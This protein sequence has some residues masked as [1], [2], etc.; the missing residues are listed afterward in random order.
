MTC[1]RLPCH[2]LPAVPVPS[3]AAST[4]L[5]LSIENVKRCV[6]LG[7]APRAD[8]LA[9]ALWRDRRET[10]EERGRQRDTSG[11][12]KAAPSARAK[13]AIGSGLGAVA[14]T[15]PVRRGDALTCAISRTRSS[16][17]I[18][19]IHWVPPSPNSK[20]ST[21]AQHAS[22]ATEDETGAE[23]HDATPSWARLQRP[24][25]RP[26]ATS[27]ARSRFAPRPLRSARRPAANRTS[28]PP[29]R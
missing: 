27:G 3:I 29:S 19:D 20:A 26:V 15:G 1:L 23:A 17:A 14:L 10:S 9:E 8:L 12:R 5:K 2:P 4:A 11:L 18:Q 22:M 16:R 21:P 25:L 7:P 28:R 24:A 13:A 6:W